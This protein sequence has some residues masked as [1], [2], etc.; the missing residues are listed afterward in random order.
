MLTVEDCRRK[1][2]QWLDKAQSTSDPHTIA[3]MRRAADAWT[4][5][6]EQIEGANLRQ[7]RSPGPMR[8]P[9]DLAQARSD[10][11]RDPVHV[12]DVLR[13]RLHLGDDGPDNS[14]Q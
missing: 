9:A 10:Y 2:A 6:A 13:G 1:A 5:Q 14:A 11:P 4:R 8:R 3:S 7:P 12:G